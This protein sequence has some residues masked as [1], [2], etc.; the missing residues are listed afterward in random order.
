MKLNIINLDEYRKMIGGTKVY[1]GGILQ[2]RMDYF[3]MTKERLSDEALVDIDELND[4]LDNKVSFD[5]IDDV[6]LNFISQAMYCNPE[7]FIDNKV[8]NADIVKSSYN[9]GYSTCKSNKVKGLLQSFT[10]DL[11]FLVEL[12]NQGEN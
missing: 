10:D 4:I 3:G 7:Y 6:S 1:I 2:E 11:A 5:E 12:K 9:R 8:R